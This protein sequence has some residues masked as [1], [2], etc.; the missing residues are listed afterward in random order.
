MPVAVFDALRRGN[1]EG[2]GRVL[3][4]KEKKRND[5]GSGNRGNLGDGE[6]RRYLRISVIRGTVSVFLSHPQQPQCRP[7]NSSSVTSVSDGV[8][9]PTTLAGVGD[10]PSG[11]A[12]PVASG[13][14]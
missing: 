14:A 4:K 13:D 5:G 9:V 6:K 11:D 7:E 2:K 1:K 10:N 3:V 8:S 12:S